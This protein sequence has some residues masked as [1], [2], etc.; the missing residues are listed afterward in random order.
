VGHADIDRE[1]APSENKY[2][3]L[4]EAGNA[5]TFDDVVTFI[6][7]RSDSNLPLKDQLHAMWLFM[8][9]P[10]M[11]G[12]ILQ[13]GDETLFHLAHAT[14][15]PIVIV[16]TKYDRLVRTKEAE[17]QEE[18]DS[19]SG[20]VLRERGKEEARKAFDRYIR[21]LERTLRDMNTPK[22][23]HVNV[24]IQPGYEAGISSLVQVTGDVV[25]DKLKLLWAIAQPET[26]SRQ[27]KMNASIDIAISTMGCWYLK[28]HFSVSH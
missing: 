16:L 24:S 14:G 9:T 15:T 21:S 25:S 19:L 13:P 22:P 11:G 18:N 10:R 8:E 12:R 7:Q 6:Q 20:D 28:L 1:F 3:I 27:F 26:R 4:H 23:P 5:K 2:L 17:L